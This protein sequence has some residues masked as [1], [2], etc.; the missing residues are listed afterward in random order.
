MHQPRSQTN[1]SSPAREFSVDTRS[2]RGSMRRMFR[3]LPQVVASVRRNAVA[4]FF[5]VALSASLAFAAELPSLS[6]AGLASGSFSSMHMLLEKTILKVDVATIDVKVGPSVQEK[7]KQSLAGKG[8]SPAVEGELAKIAIGAD[9]AVIQLKF[10]RDV[11]LDQWIGGVRESLVAAEKAGLISGAV[12]QQVSDG[13]P[14]WFQPVKE[15]GYKDGDRVLYRI[16]AGGLR[17]VAVTREGQVL[18]DRTDTGTDKARI[19]LAS[20]FAPG[21]DYRQLLLSSLK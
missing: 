15:R 11:S 4:S 8:Y 5:A 12:R 21:T 2:S 7:F 20:Y 10:V 16:D 6:E 9:R 1:V 3:R 14:V 18:V 19:V 17:T 13:L